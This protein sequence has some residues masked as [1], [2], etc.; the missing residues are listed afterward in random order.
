MAIILEEM[1]KYLGAAGTTA[2][3]MTD[4]VA[5]KL[6]TSLDK[7]VSYDGVNDVVVVDPVSAGLW[8]G[9]P[10]AMDPDP[11]KFI[12]VFDDFDRGGISATVPLPLWD[13]ITGAGGTNAFRTDIHGGVINLVTAATDNDY[14]AL[15]TPTTPFDFVNAKAFWFEARFRLAEATTNESAWWFGLTEDLT[16]G[17]FQANTAGP[18]ATYDG[19]MVWKN[20][21][22][23][24]I[25]S[26][27]S[28]AGTQNTNTTMGTFV[29][30]TWTRVGFYVSGA[31]TTA[32]VTWYKELTGSG[33]LS[34]FGTTQNLTRAGLVPMHLVFGVKAGPT[35][36]AET[37][38]VDYIKAVQLR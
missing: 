35:A 15:A 29:T 26:E 37:L 16:T 23:M 17:G 11:S 24:D 31:A 25:L 6:G 14:M 34:A 1:A 8:S 10:S 2:I 38:Q 5:L 3:G 33:A 22:S 12:M 30:N 7:Q 21:A 13:T 19:V 36:A 4:G 27:T 20:E 9:C 18:L 32:V 28:N